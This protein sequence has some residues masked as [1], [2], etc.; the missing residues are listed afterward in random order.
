MN[1]IYLTTNLI[2]GK[3]YIGSH[4]GKEDDLYLG[5]GRI[6]KSAIVKYGKKNFRREILE[7]CDSALNLFLEE[8]YIKK[9]NTLKPNGYNLS[10]NGGYNIFTED[11]RNKLSNIKKDKPGPNKG[12]KFSKEQ[13]KRMSES[14]KK[15][16]RFPHSEETK[17]KIKNSNLG[18]KRSEETKQKLSESLKFKKVSKE[19]RQ[20]MSIFQKGRVK[21]K[22]ECK[23][24]S[25]SKKGNL[26][27]MFGKIP[28][29]KGLKKNKL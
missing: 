19:T 15:R 17:E 10:K 1:F 16:K 21:S 6:L 7:E 22:Q 29:N 2:N 3:Q 26:N 12:K 27:P 4:Q 23:N 8:K 20:K 9:Y 24:I 18:K 28:W 13:K 5:S 11:L 14:A 25:N